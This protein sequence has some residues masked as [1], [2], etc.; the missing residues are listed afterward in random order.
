MTESEAVNAGVAHQIGHYADAV[1]VPAGYDAIF[2]SGT[3]G[4]TEDGSLADDITGQATQAWRNVEAILT[5]AGASLADIVSV[6]QWL[7]N[8]DDM[9]DYVAVR[10][11]VLKHESASMLAVVPALVWPNIKVEIEV[12]AA[13]P[14]AKRN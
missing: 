13:V 3:P 9:A 11:Q 8:A 4:L 7:V 5:R 1:R 10:S 12:V 14:A 6:R 2:V